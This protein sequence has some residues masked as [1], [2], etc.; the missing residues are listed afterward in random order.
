M[1]V[2][3]IG[4][5]GTIGSAVVDL[6]ASE[7]DVVTAGRTSGTYRVDITSKDSIAQL[8][9]AVG[10]VDAVVCCAGSAAFKPLDKLTDADFEMSLGNKLMGQVNLVRLGTASVQDGGSITLSSGVLAREP[11][12]GASAVSLVN[13]GLEGF[14]GAAALESPRGIRVN[15]V[16]PPWVAETL[17]K[18]GMDPAPGM[19]AAKVAEAY[20]ASVMGSM[21][22]QVIDA[23]K[24]A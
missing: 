11:I 12:P 5:T 24:F 15:V 23:R 6:L 2:L 18:M 14:V 21:T 10:R 22:G 7:H 3:V 1:R 20:R 9:A 4:W 19:P 8:V 13:S 17:V 16:S